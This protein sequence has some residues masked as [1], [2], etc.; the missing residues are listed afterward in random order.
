MEEENGNKGVLVGI[1]MSYLFKS[2]W[3]WVQQGFKELE[4]GESMRV[5]EYAWLTKERYTVKMD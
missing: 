5:G 2:W 3:A 1:T 4:D